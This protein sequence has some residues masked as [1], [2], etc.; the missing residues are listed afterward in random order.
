[1]RTIMNINNKYYV[2]PFSDSQANLTVNNYARQISV[3]ILRNLKAIGRSGNKLKIKRRL[4]LGN[5]MHVG[6]YCI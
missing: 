4:I 2:N 3:N 5:D 6:N 1:M